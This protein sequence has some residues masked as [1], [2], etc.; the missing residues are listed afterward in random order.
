MYDSLKNVTLTLALS[1]MQPES[2]TKIAKVEAERLMNLL[3]CLV[4]LFASA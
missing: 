3:G 2:G 4:H 1:E